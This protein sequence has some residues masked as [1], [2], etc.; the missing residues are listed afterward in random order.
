MLFGVIT[1]LWKYSN[2]QNYCNYD[3]AIANDIDL[4]S[5]FLQLKA[6][7]LFLNPF[8]CPIG[9]YKFAIPQSGLKGVHL[10]MSANID[11][12]KKFLSASDVANILDVSRSTAYRII[13]RLNRDLEQAG[14]SVVE[15]TAVTLRRRY[16]SKL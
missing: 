8:A 13:R 11:R 12:D 2:Q 5:R 16:P 9:K 15:R 10:M 14:A 3:S 7:F 4:T 1:L 6:H